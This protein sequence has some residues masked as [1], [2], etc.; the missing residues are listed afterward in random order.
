MHNETDD[1][2]R[3]EDWVAHRFSL[4]TGVVEV[5]M[6]E[7]SRVDRMLMKDGRPRGWAEVKCRTHECGR[8]DSFA[9][10]EDKFKV[11]HYLHR[12]TNLPSLLV[13]GFMDLIAWVDITKLGGLRIVENKGEDPIED[14]HRVVL[15]PITKFNYIH[16]EEEL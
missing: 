14:S 16:P 2:R 1:D 9:I 11:M 12:A 7:M 10:D 6:P 4:K 5:S 3:R 8:F 13:V 15:I